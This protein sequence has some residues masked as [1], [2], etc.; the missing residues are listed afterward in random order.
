MPRTF[1]AIDFSLEAVLDLTEGRNRQSLAISESRLLT[2]DW[3]AEVQAGRIPLTQQI[4]L[5]AAQ[6]GLEGVLVRSAAHPEGT[7]L[8][9]FVEN[10]R[11]TSSL[12]IVTPDRL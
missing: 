7:N 10:L 11:A 5:A 8:V 2:C 4:G 3:R 9:V 1:V 6:C 12:A